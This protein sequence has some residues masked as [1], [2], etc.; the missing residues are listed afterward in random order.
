MIRIGILGDGYT[1]E[2]LVRI[3]CRHPNVELVEVTTIEHIGQEFAK[4]YPNL[5]RYAKV[6]CVK[7]DLP[8]LVQRC[9]LVFVALPH[10]LAV[11][12]VREVVGQGKKVVDLGAD[13]RFRDKNTY[14]AWYHVEHTAPELLAAAVYGLPEIYGEKIKTASVI[15]NPGCYPTT[16]ILG[17]A[18][19]LQAGLIDLDSIVIDSKSGVSGAGRT[20]ALGSHFSECNENLKPYNVGGHRHTPEIEQEL[21]ALAGRPVTVSFSPHLIPM[22]RGMLSTIYSRLNKTVSLAEVQALYRKFYAGKFFVRI[23]EPGELPQTKRLAGSNHC[24]IGLVVDQRTGRL[25]IMSALDNLVKGA[26]GQAVQNMNLMF[27]FP[28][29]QGLEYPGLYP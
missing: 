2:E 18:P 16:A 10:G 6:R 4:I 9:D 21:S 5:E 15:A 29:A 23:L 17:L 14:E 11:P 20:L 8:D 24:D 25:V 3:L 19:A 1:A 13:F 27:G 28:E 7:L 12:V 26:S 22:T